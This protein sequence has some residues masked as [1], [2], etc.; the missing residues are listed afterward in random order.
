M[1]I[2]DKQQSHYQKI[3]ADYQKA[4]DLLQEIKLLQEINKQETE[5]NDS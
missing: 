2:Q 3:K 5:E 4:M 1:I